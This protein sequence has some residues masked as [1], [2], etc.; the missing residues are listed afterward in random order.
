MRYCLEFCPNPN[1]VKIH[2]DK[3]VVTSIES[4]H[5]PNWDQETQ[6]RLVRDLFA[7]EGIT[8]VSLSPYEVFVRKGDVFEWKEM[9]SAILSCIQDCLDPQG[10]LV[11]TKRPTRGII[12]DGG[13][14]R[15]EAIED[16]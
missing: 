10:E 14:C 8:S 7:T 1:S 6:P 12:D 4:Y 2:V 15:L 3:I 9:I 16:F 11:E 5:S 13:R